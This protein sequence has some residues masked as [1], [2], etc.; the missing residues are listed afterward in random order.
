MAGSSKKTIAAELMEVINYH[1]MK[2]HPAYISESDAVE[3][4]A[5]THS[6]LAEKYV[7]DTVNL[8]WPGKVNK[9]HVF[10]MFSEFLDHEDAGKT[11]CDMIDFVMS[12]K[13]RYYMD[14]HTVLK[15]HET[16]LDS[17]ASSMTCF[18][19]MADELAIYTLSDLTRKHTVIITN[20]K[21]WTTVHPDVVIDDIYHLLNMCDVKLLFLGNCKFGRLRIRPKNCNN[22]VVYAPPRFPWP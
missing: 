22:P 11:R 17:W 5:F 20:T 14:G 6:E 18:T 8:Y 9:N 21:P 16:N 7:L 4:S 13:K 2:A 10:E 12:N 1:Q 19:N 15:M 3:I